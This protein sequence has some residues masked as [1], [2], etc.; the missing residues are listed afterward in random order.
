[1]ISQIPKKLSRKHVWL[2]FVPVLLTGAIDAT[3]QTY[4]H[5]PLVVQIT[6]DGLRGDIPMRFA[7]RLPEGGFHQ[8][9]HEGVWCT[10]T[11]YRHSTT[12]TA[13]GHATLFTGA[14]PSEHGLVAND[15]YDRGTGKKVYCVRDESAPPIPVA[16]ASGEASKEGRS[17]KKLKGSTWGD[18]LKLATGGESKVFSVSIKDRGA[19]LP[20]GHSG[21]AYW[22]DPKS[23]GFQ[24][25]DYYMDAYPEWVDSWNRDQHAFEYRGKKWELLEDSN[26]YSALDRD[27]REIEGNIEGLGTTL[28]KDLSRLSDE[29]LLNAL[30]F[31]PFGDEITLDFATKLV[32]QEGLGRDETPDLLAISLSCLDYVNHVYG[33]ESLESEDHFFRLNRMLGEFF[34]SLDERIGRENVMIVLCSDHGF[35]PIPEY[36]GRL[37]IPSGVLLSP[38]LIKQVNDR[39]KESLGIEESLAIVFLNP[40]LYL[41]HERIR[42]L[43]LE[44]AV[45]EHHVA[46]I[47]ESLPGVE[48][49]FTRSEILSAPSEGESLAARV[50]RSFSPDRSGDVFLIQDS[51][52]YLYSKRGAYAAMHGS[53]YN[54]DRHV[55]LFFLH[56]GLTAQ[57]V[58][59]AVTPNDIVPTLSMLLGIGAPAYSSGSPISEVLEDFHTTP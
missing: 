23:G 39:L 9:I 51:Y 1:M 52:W 43:G 46:R 12:F 35:A 20:G 19:V 4:P 6:I 34:S 25:S 14:D 57:R 28:P 54:Y 55:P 49:A 44:I 48:R 37:R 33:P 11:F 53:P 21:T 47:M 26:A 2:T 13:V 59:R 31:T 8:L 38:Y 50:S 10:Q 32:E 36:A 24:T 40:C 17:P 29:N 7:D 27:N 30:R 3:G 45:V 58:D 22:Y 56:P 41:N 5:I 42:D 15:W 16:G 18:Q